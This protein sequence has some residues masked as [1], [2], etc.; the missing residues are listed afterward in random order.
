VEYDAM[1]KQRANDS[2]IVF[3]ILRRILLDES[4]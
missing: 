1:R 3:F 2:A 4:Q